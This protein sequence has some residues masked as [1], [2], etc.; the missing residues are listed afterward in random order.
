M[1]KD[2]FDF[3]EP[4][5]PECSPE[6]HAYHQGQWDMATR[7]KN[8]YEPENHSEARKQELEAV[9]K[10]FNS[11]ESSAET[12]LYAERR[13]NAINADLGIPTKPSLPEGGE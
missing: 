7:V 10:H 12:K 3:V 6:R 8:Q 13:L 9:T 11:G 2:I 1:S 5:E 4:C